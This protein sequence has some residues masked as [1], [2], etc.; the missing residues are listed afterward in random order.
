MASEEECFALINDLLQ[1]HFF[2]SLVSLQ[3]LSI[4]REHQSQQ[5]VSIH[6][7]SALTGRSQP[8]LYN[9]FQC[10]LDLII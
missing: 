2:V 5:I 6:I 8:L 7:L 3:F 9:L 10:C 1:A 4:G